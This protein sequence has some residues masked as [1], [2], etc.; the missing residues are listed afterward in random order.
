MERRASERGPFFSGAGT[1]PSALNA[2]RSLP[3]GRGPEGEPGQV[4]GGVTTCADKVEIEKTHAQR[5]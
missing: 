2:E 5:S 4:V 1:T 3:P